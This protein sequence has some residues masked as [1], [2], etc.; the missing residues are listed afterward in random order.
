MGV[1]LKSIR[2]ILVETNI[3]IINNRVVLKV[4]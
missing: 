4:T 2:K 3:Y 1:L